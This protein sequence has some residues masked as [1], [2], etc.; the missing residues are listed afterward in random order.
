[1]AR[2]GTLTLTGFIALISVSLSLSSASG[3]QPT[4]GALSK[5]LA[6]AVLGYWQGTAR[7]PAQGDDKW[8]ICFKPDGTVSGEVQSVR[9]GF[10]TFAGTYLPTDAM[11]GIATRIRNLTGPPVVFNKG[12]SFTLKPTSS[13]TLEGTII[14]DNS[15][16]P[17][18]MRYTTR[19]KTSC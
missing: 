15:P 7:S 10:I 8:E 12:S 9:G 3:Q 18:P 5:E 6:D 4:G 17:R 13:G 14:S 2:F 19:T 11:D 1:M 16:G